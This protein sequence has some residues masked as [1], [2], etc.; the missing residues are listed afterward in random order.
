MEF[1][2]RLILNG[3][4]K[5]VMASEEALSKVVDS[6]KFAIFPRGQ[7]KGKPEGYIDIN[8]LRVDGKVTGDGRVRECFVRGDV[9]S[10]EIYV[11][12]EKQP[13]IVANNAAEL[14]NLPKPFPAYGSEL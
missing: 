12:D 11:N 5:R 9:H 6:E 4:E 8:Y 7:F 3:Q 14:F 2:Y 10:L 13:Q 1:S